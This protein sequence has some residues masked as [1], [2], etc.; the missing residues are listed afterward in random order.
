MIDLKELS[1]DKY[2]GR[3]TGSNGNKLAAKLISDRFN[4]LK[5]ENFNDSYIQTFNFDRNGKH[6][7]GNNI[8]AFISGKTEETIII[9]AHFDHIGIKNKQIYNGAD[10]NASGVAALLTYADYF[11]KNP[12]HHQLVFIAFDAEEMN[13]KGSEYFVNH[14]PIA[15]NLIKL[16]I[17]MDMIGIND[18]NELYVS[19]THQYPEIKKYIF[20]KNPNPKILFGHDTPELGKDDWTKQSDHYSF[21]IKGIP[22]LY[23]GVE[24]HPYYHQ[25]NDEFKNINQEFYLASVE[26]ILDII[27]NIDSENNTS[28][29]FRE[30]L[31][32]DKFD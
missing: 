23:F 9:S 28:K 11:K 31:I 3:E 14:L 27:K 29:I 2:E 15:K 24:N 17:N 1:S 18:K 10:D 25:E 19:G 4:D 26:A 6:I 8:V 20:T 22:F 16:N 12:P 5:L 30:K 13:K 21:F 32:M 7:E